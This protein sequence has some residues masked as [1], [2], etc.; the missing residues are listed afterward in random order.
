MPQRMRRDA[1]EPGPFACRSKTA[2]AGARL[3]AIPS[4]ADILDADAAVVNYEADIGSPPPRQPQKGEQPAGNWL[5]LH[6]ALC[7]APG[8]DRGKVDPA[9]LQVHLR[10]PQGENRPRPSAGVEAKH[11][12]KWQIQPD[13]PAGGSCDVQKPRGL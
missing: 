10:P 11:D 2:V 13:I 8:P 12:V 3:V 9:C 7:R 6:L 5:T 1:S 4:A